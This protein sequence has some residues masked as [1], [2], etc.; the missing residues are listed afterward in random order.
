MLDESEIYVKE[1]SHAII[2]LYKL[3]IEDMGYDMGD[4]NNEIEYRNYLVDDPIEFKRP[5]SA[6][7]MSTGD[8]FSVGL[9]G[10][11]GG[12]PGETGL[13][14]GMLSFICF[15]ESGHQFGYKMTDKDL[16]GYDLHDA[17]GHKTYGYGLLYHPV[18]KKFMDTIKKVWT[19]QELE[20]LFKIHAKATS[21]KI[22]S[23]A[24]RNNVKLNQ[25]QKDAIASACYN[26]GPGFLNKG[27][28]KL[29]AKNPNNPAIKNVW[30]HLSDA[31][32]KRYPGLI[33]RRQAEA[34]WY[35]GQY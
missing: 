20:I 22:D 18:S 10:L 11:V 27:I 26:F 14:D 28:C 23:W 17:G 33:R 31:Q 34:N 8:G 32:G 2:N 12:D 16:N 19:Q 15:Y 35:F 30:A 3:A 1:L 29:I 4:T 9:N 21:N 24:Q 13:S 6:D 7:D 25:N 5:F